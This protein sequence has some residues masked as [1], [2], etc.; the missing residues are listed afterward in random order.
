MVMSDYNTWE[1]LSA[2][3]QEAY[4]EVGYRKECLREAEQ[5]LTDA[6]AMLDEAQECFRAAKGDL[7]NYAIESVR[8]KKEET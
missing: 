8:G 2:S 3:I 4:E 1:Q 7:Y 5:K 6:K